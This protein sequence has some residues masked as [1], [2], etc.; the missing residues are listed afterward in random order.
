MAEAWIRHYG[1]N[2]FSVKSAGT[3]PEGVNNLAIRVMEEVG[4]D[5]FHYT[6]NHVDEYANEVFD[7]VITVCNNAKEACPYIPAN[8]KNI[9]HSFKDP[10]KATGAIIEQLVVYRQVRDEI[11]EFS[12]EFVSQLLDEEE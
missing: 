5:I 2:A 8:K 1:N 12:Q 4:I 11:K 9:H 10:A 3:H 7:Y 6:S